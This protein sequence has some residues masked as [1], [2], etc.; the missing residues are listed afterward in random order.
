MSLLSAILLKIK[1]RSQAHQ[2]LSDKHLSQL[3]MPT[4]ALGK[5]QSLLGQLASIYK[6]VPLR[7]KRKVLVLSAADH[8]VVAQ[9]VS[10]YPQIT[11]AIV[12]T[13]LNGGAAI[14]SFCQSANCDLKIVDAG[15][16]EKIEHK[17]LIDFSCG[18]G[19][20]D[21][22]E[23]PA[24]SAA[25]CLKAI[26]N[27]VNLAL[28]LDQDYDI[29]ALG[30]MG[31]GNTTSAAALASFFCSQ[32]AAV[33]TGRGTGVDDKTYLKKISCVE[34]ALD[35]NESTVDDPLA[36]LAQLGG[37]EIATMTG[38]ILG[39]S[40]CSKAIALDGFITGSAA[41]VATAIEPKVKDYLIAGHQSAEQGHKYVLDQLG[42]SPVVTMDMCLGEGVG[43]ALALQVIDTGI[44][45]TRSMMTLDEAL[46]L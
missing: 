16:V 42:L 38:L 20:N 14:N 45:L 3:A 46:N 21:I 29:L 26:E 5:V 37:F 12:K 35:L 23:G 28:S 4:G 34:S 13:A 27:G 36:V 11:A 19:T 25:S 8:G 1:R 31:I 41:L 24:M 6:E 10:K 17:D 43:A 9:G 32:S 22:S 15:L 2:S 39:W 33:M 40:A 7:K 30:E 18:L 44:D